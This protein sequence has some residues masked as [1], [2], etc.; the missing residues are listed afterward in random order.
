MADYLDQLAE[1][2]VSLRPEDLPPDVQTQAR[3]QILDT[4]G[5]IVGGT[6]AAP[7]QR[8]A[9][10]LADPAGACQGLGLGVR[11]SP[12]HAAL[13][14]GTAGT[15]LDFDGGH[16]WSGGHP[17]V[18]VLPAALAF[19]ESL[20]RSGADLLTAFVAGAEVA[21]RIGLAKGQLD[22]TLH[23]HGT[24]PVVGAVAAAA[25]LCGLTAGELRRAFDL[26][27]T[28]TLVTSWNT[29]F[30]GAT[31]RHV[32]AGLGAELALHAVD[33]TLAGWEGER[34]GVGVVF[35]SIA[36]AGIVRR[37]AVMDLGTTWEFT[38]SYFKPY[39]FARFGHPAIDVL[40]DL[41]RE[42]R[43]SAD[44][45]EHIRI[46]TGALGAR[47][48]EQRPTTELQARFSL[49]HA[50]ALLV[51]R[52]TIEA[53][54]FR[55]EALDDPAVRAVAARVIVEEDPE[56]EALSPQWRGATVEVLLRQ[57]R[58]LRGETGH[59]RGDPERPLSAEELAAKF[60]ALVSP[61]VG[62]APAAAARAAIDQLALLP[63]LQPLLAP[64]AGE[65][66]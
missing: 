12:R 19:A 45:V 28:L 20:G 16:R 29:A 7:V 17:A 53:W 21:C 52:G 48:R 9:R 6:R 43:F 63:S 57:G 42:H 64:L 33:W 32:Y 26:V 65:P 4:L 31:V 14:H 47:M 34:D 22:P 27:S 24:W 13:V 49:P 61:V 50:A 60:D 15:W 35:G 1:F 5:V 56:W 58:R 55:E 38:A 37:R 8:L 25:R 44:E 11:L 54:A 41:L 18:H 59:P 62:A 51:T 23:P 3:A 40:V 66:A 46:R 39:P 2:A 30:A 10:R 36:A